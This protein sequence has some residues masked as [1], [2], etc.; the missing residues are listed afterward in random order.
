MTSTTAADPPDTMELINP[1]VT[2]VVIPTNPPIIL[3]AAIITK[4]ATLSTTT[5]LNFE[6][7]IL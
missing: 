3:N 6:V 2:I 4:P 7:S 1:G 5:N